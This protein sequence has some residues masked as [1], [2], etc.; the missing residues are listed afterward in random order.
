MIYKKIYILSISL[1]F[2]VTYGLVDSQ[3]FCCYILTSLAQDNSIF[4]VL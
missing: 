2:L 4:T 1:V 3:K